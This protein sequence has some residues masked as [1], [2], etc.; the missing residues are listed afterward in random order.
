VDNE[1]ERQAKARHDRELNQIYQRKSF[2]R[3][4][5]T[6]D[7]PRA[8]MKIECASL[9]GHHHMTK[10]RVLLVQVEVGAARDEIDEEEIFDGEEII[11]QAYVHMG[12]PT[13][14]QPQNLGW[15]QKVSYKGKTEAVREKVERKSKAQAKGG[16]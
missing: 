1:G 15:R 11:P 16:H 7:L 3:T 6:K 4:M 8:D 14:Q 12:T 13:F 10:E 2:K 5:S 9:L